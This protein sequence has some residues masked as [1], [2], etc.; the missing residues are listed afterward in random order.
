MRW[1]VEKGDVLGWNPSLVCCP[2][3]EK[4]L[5][6]RIP[7]G[8]TIGSSRDETNY[9]FSFC[10][11]G[12]IITPTISG[13]VSDSTPLCGFRHALKTVSGRHDA[14]NSALARGSFFSVL[15]VK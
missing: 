9:F 7:A 11:P 6:C 15:L 14:N 4:S 13:V 8:H 1:R 10:Y 5:K 12:S 2:K 3:W